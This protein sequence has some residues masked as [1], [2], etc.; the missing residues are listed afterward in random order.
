MLDSTL[1]PPTV[2][3]QWSQPLIRSSSL[4]RSQ[5]GLNALHVDSHRPQDYI[6]NTLRLYCTAFVNNTIF[7]RVTPVP[8]I[9]LR[10]SG[11]YQELLF[12]LKPSDHVLYR[13][14]CIF[15]KCLIKIF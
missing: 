1:Q 9:C 15:V 3:S 4:G 6:Q 10:F 12:F 8:F 5:Q 13:F 2:L 11:G 7:L 14:L